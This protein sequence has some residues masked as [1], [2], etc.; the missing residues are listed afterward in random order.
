SFVADPETVARFTRVADLVIGAVRVP[1]GKAPYLVTRQM[2]ADMRPGSVIIDVAI[3]QGGCVETSRPTTLA[4][5]TFTVNGVVHY[6]VPNFT[7]NIPRTAS[8]TLSLVHLPY[9]AEVA[10]AGIETARRRTEPIARGIYMHD[11]NVQLPEL[12]RRLGVA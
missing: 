6:C 3:D 4:Q 1:G 11:G 2:V 9:V 5:P 10:R 7:A 12:A 8:K